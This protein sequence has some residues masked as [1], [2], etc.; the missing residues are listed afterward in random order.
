MGWILGV[1]YMYAFKVF[2]STLIALMI[3]IVFCAGFKANKSG[4]MVSA[5]I[6]IIY[7]LAIVAIWG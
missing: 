6:A 7:A 1:N 3:I 2:V 5:A 4:K